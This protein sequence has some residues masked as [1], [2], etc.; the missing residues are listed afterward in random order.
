VRKVVVGLLSAA[1]VTGA[2]ISLPV[3][4]VAAPPVQPPESTSAKVSTGDERPNPFEDKRRALRQEAITD[5]IAGRAK[6]QKRGGSTVVNMGKTF[7]K[8]TAGRKIP[9][10]GVDQ[11][12]E[13]SR[14]KTDKIFVI[15]AEFGTKRHPDFPDKDTTPTIA[16]PAT[17]EGPLHNAILQPN[18]TEDNTTV[19]QADYSAEHY[20]Q[21]Y[22]GTGKNVDSL[23][24]YF[25][26]QSSGRYSVD[27]TVTDWVKVDFNEARYGRSHDDPADANGDDPAVCDDNVCQ[28]SENLVTDAALKW[29][30]A[31]QK[32]GRTA[33]QIKKDLQAFDVYD[34]YDYDADG[35]F[36][37]ADGY[38]DHLQVVHAGGDNS[39]GD[40]QQGEDA[41]WAHRGY[42]LPTSEGITGPAGNLRGGTQIGDT[43]LWAGDYTMQPENGGLSVFA[44]EYAHDLGLPDDYDTSGGQNNTAYWTL[45]SQSRLSAAGEPLGTRPGDLGAWNKIQLG[46][47]DYETVVAGQKRTLDLGP[48]EYN[49]DK[50]QGVVVVLPKKRV[51]TEFGAP[52]AGT[53]QFFS[54]NRNDLDSTMKREFDLTG[55][56][57]ASVSLK[58]RYSIEVDYD[59]LYLQGST[60]GGKTWK[61]IDG[62]ANGVPFG[63]D[64]SGT[65]SITGTTA[66]AWVDVKAS[67]DAYAG[68]PM[69]LRLRYRT[70]MAASEGGFFADEVTVS[71]DGVPLLT[72]GAEAATSWT[73][74]NFKIVKTSSTDDFENFYV[75]GHR[76]YVGF[77][78]YLKTGPYNIPNAREKPDFA[79]HYAY[80]EG[81]L[82]SYWDTSQLENNTIEHRGKGLNLYIDSRPEPVYNTQGRTW[83]SYVQMY[84]APFSLKK[85]DSLNLHLNGLSAYVRGKAAV[86]TFDDTKQYLFPEIPLFGV[87]LPAVG[88][89]IQILEQ[90][91]TAMKIAIS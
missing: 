10:S 34:R 59:Y 78:K 83:S 25:E 8:F 4:A 20:R 33:A 36:D 74:K 19:W 13:L 66:G 35:N 50:A 12:V 26:A 88:V 44:H 77:D 62:T 87:T 23:K 3:S 43:G 52:F 38:I 18:R 24:T 80:Q 31:Q 84:D 82:I 85:A 60:D 67:L 7:G 39:D 2:G 72:D 11:Y 91:G 69:Q 81:L 56:T 16:G 47:L 17:F 14:E 71:A 90:K 49:T 46:W 89:K 22:F 58:A 53:N 9:S 55:K 63:K 54:G 76:S 29:V 57:T 15:L 40:P 32:A 86:S 5:V 75:A 61:A 73:L 65:P 70:D 1:M 28:N 68:A 30:E 6:A 21:L 79:E 42:V 27:G 64:G 41:I 45:M 51:V 37:E 48:Q